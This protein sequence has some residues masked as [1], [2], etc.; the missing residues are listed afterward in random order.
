MPLD[1]ASLG[2]A[3]NGAQ[4][5]LATARSGGWAVNDVGGQAILKAVRH[6]M[7]EIANVKSRIFHVAQPMKLGTSPDALV[8]VEFNKLVA[9]GD[10]RSFETNLDLFVE[11][12]TQVEEAVQL[13]MRNYRNVEDDARQRIQRAGQ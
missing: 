12:L 11:V 8:M 2:Q 5:F 1:P 10:A 3:I 13:A 9:T 4:Q 7:D 6:G